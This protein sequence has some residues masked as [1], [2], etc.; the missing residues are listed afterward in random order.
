MTPENEWYNP[1]QNAL[2]VFDFG[3]Y[4]ISLSCLLF[5]LST[6]I[7]F[8]FGYGWNGVKLLL[9]VIGIL[10]F[11]I[12]T[13]LLWPRPPWK[14]DREKSN[15]ETAFQ[16]AVQRL[17]PL[18]WYELRKADRISTSAKLFVSSLFTLSISYI[19]EAVFNIAL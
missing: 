13:F 1:S 5:F 6:V 8:L 12:S 10:L 14:D 3:L 16:R 7:S 11:G 17:P 4:I 15:E 18:R 19:M 9:F 2:R